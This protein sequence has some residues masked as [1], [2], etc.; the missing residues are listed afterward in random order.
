M[1]KTL[2]VFTPTYNRAYCIENLYYSLCAQTCRD[3]VWLVVDDGSTDDTEEKIRTLAE[4]SDFDIKYV[5]KENGGKHTALMLGIELTET[6][7]F[8]C[9]DSD[10]TLTNDAVETVA[11]K[12]EKHKSENLLGFYFRQIDKTGKSIAPPYPDGLERVGISDLYNIYGYSGDTVIVLKTALIKGYRFPVFE[13]EKFV[14]ERVF[15]NKINHIAPMLLCE[16]QIYISEY[17]ADGYTKNS[18]RLML[19]NPYGY[20]V[21]CLSEAYNNPHFIYKAKKYAQYLA[22]VSFFK[23]KKDVLR[24][25]DRCTFFTKLAAILLKAHYTRLFKEAKNKELH[26]PE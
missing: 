13:G 3:F 1:D 14:T 21:D 22:A 11:A 2:T 26:S 10:D 15:Y 4:S 6:E 17:L 8:L 18:A 19:C 16:E 5:K 25:Y 9:V 20:S 7:L 24:E 12:N 23:L